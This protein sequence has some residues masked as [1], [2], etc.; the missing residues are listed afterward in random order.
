VRDLQTDSIISVPGPVPIANA[1]LSASE[2]LAAVIIPL[3]GILCYM[4]S[5][6]GSFVLDEQN[7]IVDN[8]HIRHL[9]PPWQAL[10]SSDNASRPLVGLF[11]AVNYA[12]SGVNP[13]S[14]HVLNLLIHICAALALYGI[15]RRTLLTER[16]KERF[17]KD[18]NALGLAVALI[19][20][21]HPL[22]TQSVTYVIQRSESMMGM[23]YL[24]CLYCSIRSYDSQHKW[25]W[26]A[27]AIAACAGGML[28]KPIMVTAPLA[29]LLYDVAFGAQSMKETLRRRWP[30]FVG[31]AATWI[32]LAAT[33]MGAPANPTAG[34]GLKSMSWWDYFKSEPRVVV[35]YLRLSIWPSPLCL[36]Y[37]GWP[38]AKTIREI[39]PYAI[40]LGSLAIVTVW[41]LIRR[42]PAGFLGAWFF[43]ILSASSGLVPIA[44]L[45]FEHR[46]YLPLAAVVAFVVLG[47]YYLWTRFV[48]RFHVVGAGEL[49][50]GHRVGLVAVTL[51]VVALG[52]VTAMRNID[53]GSEVVMW[54]DVVTK[55]PDN[56]RGHSNLGKALTEIGRIDDAGNQFREAVRLN[57]GFEYAQSNLGTALYYEGKLTEAKAQ[58]A[59]AL[60]LDPRDS[61]AHCVLGR[62]LSDLGQTSEAIDEFAAAIRLKPDFGEAYLR[63]GYELEKA[64][65]VPEAKEQYRLAL[66]FSP[67]WSEKISSHLAG[68][69]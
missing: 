57:P 3:A 64:G 11:D 20:L 35:Y 51:I 24:L 65:R 43:L 62:V 33:I 17:G 50:S 9:W 38:V 45:V 67:E 68:L 23:F 55:R 16:L 66:R 58:L 8:P 59:I 34:F 46:M 60:A 19:W 30:L 2:R 61:N 7:W 12:I 32:V 54:T 27:S 41:A 18:S 15:V 25:L 39:L 28:S 44:D 26:Y 31:L 37:Q 56:P 36:D 40:I 14:Y 49:P 22:Q 63:L 6:Q 5:F 29:V 47:S 13:W 52:F 48:D 1:D 53:Y 10:F 21:V 4:N 69:K 42:R